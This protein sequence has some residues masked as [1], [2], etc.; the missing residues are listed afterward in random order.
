[1]WSDSL[2]EFSIATEILNAVRTEAQR[3]PDA[4]VQKVG[5]QL[6]DL[7]GVEVESLRFCFEALV[8]GTEL[9]PLALEIERS[10]GDELNLA[11]LE[12]EES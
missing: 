11:W 7:S 6:G 8:Q 3:R 10:P 2:H 9:D 4:R 1:V 12:V 5:L